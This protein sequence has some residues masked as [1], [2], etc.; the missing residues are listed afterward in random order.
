LGLGVNYQRAD[1]A[2]ESQFDSTFG[3]NPDP[4]T[5]SHAAIEGD[6]DDVVA[7]LSVFFKPIDGMRLGLVWR[8]GGDF[9]LEGDAVFDLNTSACAPGAGFPTGAPPAPTTGT[10]CAGGLT[11]SA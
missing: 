5:D 7:D 4:A 6:D 2:L 1:V 10:L 9:S 11:A 8:Q 3:I